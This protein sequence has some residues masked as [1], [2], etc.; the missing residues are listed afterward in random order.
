[1]NIYLFSLISGVLQ[2]ATEFLPVSSSGHLAL[3]HGVFGFS[4]PHLAFDVLLHTGTAAAVVIAYRSEIKRLLPELRS[5]VIKVFTGGFSYRSC[6]P[7]EKLCAMLFV[8]TLPLAAGVFVGDAVSSLAS[9]VRA[10]GILLMINAAILLLYGA[11]I[12]R[13]K[14]VPIKSAGI[15]S[16]LIIGFLQLF[17]AAPGI[18]RSGVTITGGVCEGLS[19]DDAAKYSFLLSVPATLGAAVIDVKDVASS[20]GSLPGTLPCLI[21]TL[22]AFITGLCAIGFIKRTAKR[23]NFGIFAIYCFAAGLAACIYG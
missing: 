16:A 21:G 9:S 18:S 3:L 1:M 10:V 6:S 17:A 14:R 11:A 12:K 5:L 15:K 19:G 4:K 22:A 2:G 8:S 23:T 20:G 13:K 7:G